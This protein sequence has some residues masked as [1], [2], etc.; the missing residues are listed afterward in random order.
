MGVVICKNHV[1]RPLHL[2]NKYR[3]I[4]FSS[5]ETFFCRNLENVGMSFLGQCNVEINSPSSRLLGPLLLKNH[6]LE[7][8]LFQK[9]INGYIFYFLGQLFGGQLFWVICPWNEFEETKQCD[10]SCG[11]LVVAPNLNLGSFFMLTGS[12][13]M[14]GTFSKNKV[15]MNKTKNIG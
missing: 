5:L 7:G 10:K 13:K 11:K 4:L 8:S 12:Q 15:Q 9:I 14:P 6:G 3:K 1:V 2:F